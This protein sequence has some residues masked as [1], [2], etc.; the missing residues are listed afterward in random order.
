VLVLYVVQW[1]SKS[2]VANALVM[3]NMTFFFGHIIA[4]IT[5]YLGVAIVYELLPSF[6]KRPWRT[7]RTVSLAWNSV[8]AMVLM[9]SFHH[10]YMDFVQPRMFQDMGQIM[11]YFS[12]VPAAVVSIFGGLAVVYASRMRWTLA[13]VL[14]FLGLMGWAVGG[15]G[16]LIDSTISANFRFHNT[17]WVVAHFHTYYIM[18]VVLMIL[19]FASS[20]SVDLSGSA[21]HR[22]T[23]WVVLLL[24]LIG[25][26]GFVAMFYW[27]GIQSIPR[28]YA[29]YPQ[30]LLSGTADARISLVFIV[31]LL[32]GTVLY[33]WE[34]GRRLI[35]CLSA[36]QADVN[37]VNSGAR[38]SFAPHPRR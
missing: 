27:A 31:L 1:C 12:A 3:K 18:G 7:N 23:R 22:A 19:G 35:G 11:S 28:R 38:T 21:E 24:F 15:V 6:S 20:L 8:L 5:L 10:L 14:L 30:E 16:A 34:N 29:T 26:Y 2:F 17:L 4:N 37:R 9:A 32:I 13:S 33:L 36:H 25:G